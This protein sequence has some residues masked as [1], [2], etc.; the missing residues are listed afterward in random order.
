M[1]L[2][3]QEPLFKPYED[4]LSIFPIRFKE[5]W[6]F[7]KLAESSFWPAEELRLKDDIEDWKNKLTDSERETIK[8]VLC[9]FAGADSIVNE[10]LV[11]NI[12]MK[13]SLPE[14]RCFYGFQI[15][16]ENIHGEA[17]SMM[18]DTFIKDPREKARLQ[19][20]MSHNEMP[21]IKKMY[22]WAIK[23][24]HRKP[25]NDS[26]LAYIHNFAL[27]MIAF[28]C[29]EGLMFSPLFVVPFWAKDSGILPGFAH[30]NELINRDEAL[31]FQFACYLFNMIV[32]K[33]SEDLVRHVISEA[34]ECSV[35]LAKESMSEA[36]NRGLRGLSAKQMIDYVYFM[37][38]VMLTLLGLSKVSNFSSCPIPFMERI[39]MSGKSNFFERN[40]SEYNI[41]GFEDEDGNEKE[42]DNNSIVDTTDDF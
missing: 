7:Y 26:E 20:V 11:H 24:V 8:Y 6:K 9:F 21:S 36:H 5:I 3:E 29:V 18:I 41:A 35:E 37:Q 4:R 2:L 31:H 17:Y 1:S 13:T 30:S 42:D 12:Y 16:M 10:N 33:P 25:D 32:N 22:N 34:V 14:V 40:V 27:Q 19:D 23:W 28:A 38:D 15:A 39:S